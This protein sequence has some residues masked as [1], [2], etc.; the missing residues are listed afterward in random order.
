M[1]TVL[2]TFCVWAMLI[3]VVRRLGAPPCGGYA[4]I[5]RI[6]ETKRY[7]TA[8]ETRKHIIKKCIG[9]ADTGVQLIQFEPC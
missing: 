5:F 1:L 7:G 2:E 9:R 6:H 8:L 3:I 4:Y